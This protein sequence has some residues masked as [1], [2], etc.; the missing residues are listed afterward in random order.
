MKLRVDLH[1][2]SAASHDGRMTIEEIICA[3]RS[4]GLQAVAIC[5]HERVLPPQLPRDDGFLVIPGVEFSM[6]GGHLLGL[7]L[8]QPVEKGTWSETVDAIHRSGGL[9]VL[10]HPFQR[11]VAPEALHEIATLLDGAE[12]YNA[13]A[14][15]KNPRANMQAA[16]FVERHGLLPFA[17]SDAHV[18]R[19]VGNAG[20]ELQ[21]EAADLAS[22]RAAL[23]RGDGVPFGRR[24]RELD[25]ARSQWTALQKRRA[26]ARARC[27]WALF[28]G[29]CLWNDL[30]KKGE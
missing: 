17:G 11:S 23:E 22:I 3:A 15:R 25:V 19:E 14:A 21:V 13:R 6:P 8:T 27:R 12:V 26:G 24:G 20:V 28:A 4:A 30:R 1:V 29:K 16:A 5:D 10:A 9:A 18:V 7:F 2:H